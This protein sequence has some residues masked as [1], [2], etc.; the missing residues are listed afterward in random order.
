MKKI[1]LILVL[2]S[3]QGFAQAVSGYVFSQ[4][5]DNYTPVVGTNS[6]ATGDDG[7]QN[8]VAFDFLLILA[9]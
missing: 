8:N 2:I 4:T 6:T 7:I 1:V 5:T 9:A 3:A